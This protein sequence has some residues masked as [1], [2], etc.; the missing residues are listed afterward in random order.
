M[1]Y[2]HYLSSI[3]DNSI[4]WGPHRQHKSIAGSNSDSL[5]SDFFHVTKSLCI[6]PS[7]RYRGLVPRVSD[8]TKTT[9]TMIVTMVEFE[10][11]CKIYHWKTMK[12]GI[13]EVQSSSHMISLDKSKT[14]MQVTRLAW[15]NQ[16]PSLPVTRQS[17]WCRQWR[18]PWRGQE[19]SGQPT[20]GRAPFNKDLI[21]HAKFFFIF[22]IF[23][24]LFLCI[25]KW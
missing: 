6:L 8:N 16:R 22:F 15:T 21:Y 7:A 20:W 9:G 13:K 23:S 10:A 2:I 18:E 3:I 17:W 1:F 4:V 24:F 25:N 11:T 5:K 14:S 19:T 12:S